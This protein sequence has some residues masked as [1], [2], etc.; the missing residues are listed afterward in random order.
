MFFF[1]FEMQSETAHVTPKPARCRKQG[2]A[3][4]TKRVFLIIV[5]LV[6]VQLA[7]QSQ[8]KLLHSGLSGAPIG[9]VFGTR[10]LTAA[11]T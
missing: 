9:R 10:V 6:K 8:E 4:S 1:L 3:K 11:L 2:A 7:L 5:A